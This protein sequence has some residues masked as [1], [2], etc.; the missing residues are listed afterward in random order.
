MICEKFGML[1][2][3]SSNALFSKVK[4]TADHQKSVYSPEENFNVFTALAG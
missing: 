3:W 4:V 1:N 2:S